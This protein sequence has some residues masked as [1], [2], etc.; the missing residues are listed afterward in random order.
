MH[1]SKM[2]KYAPNRCPWALKFAMVCLRRSLPA[3]GKVRSKQVRSAA[4]L[5]LDPGGGPVRRHRSGSKATVTSEFLG[6][7][8]DAGETGTDHDRHSPLG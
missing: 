4:H 5:L 2:L 3:G 7:M 8:Q 1:F 6:A